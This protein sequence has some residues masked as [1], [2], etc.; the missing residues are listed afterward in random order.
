MFIG[1]Y[2]H[3][4]DPKGRLAVPAKFRALLKDRVVVTKGLDGCLTLYPMPVF[5]EF[6]KELSSLS[7]NQ[8]KNRSHV[9]N[10]LSG[11]TDVT[12][13]NQGRIMIPDN[14]RKFAGLTKAAVITG[15]Y[16]RLE[17][18]D[19]EKWNEYRENAEKNSDEIAENL[20]K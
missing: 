7:P 18:W 2:T 14:L 17:I 10:Q 13:D 1:E 9:R 3:S 20:E 11:A 15:L 12:F 4:I 19:Q 5:E 16:D 6:A 8:S